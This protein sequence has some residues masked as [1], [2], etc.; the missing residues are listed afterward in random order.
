MPRAVAF[1]RS[2]TDPG[3]KFV[4]TSV[5]KSEYA[6][7]RVTWLSWED[8]GADAIGTGRVDSY[9]PRGLS[10]MELGEDW[11]YSETSDLEN[12]GVSTW[13]MGGVTLLRIPIEDGKADSAATRAVDRFG[14]RLRAIGQVPRQYQ[15]RLVLEEVGG[16]RRDGGATVASEGRSV[17]FLSGSEKYQLSEFEAEVAQYSAVLLPRME[18]IHIGTDLKVTIGA[19]EGDRLQVGVSGYLRND[20]GRIPIQPMSEMPGDFSRIL[21]GQR[22][23]SEFRTVSGA[24]GHWT[25][26]LSLPSKGRAGLS[27]E[28]QAL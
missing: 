25:I 28:I 8:S 3:G 26:P 16:A 24:G 1:Q 11:I 4:L 13:D 17:E 19:P 22:D 9:S 27:I 6:Q 5:A 15:V 2:Y 10:F 18:W 12:A 14:A 20:L 23:W 7:R 21:V